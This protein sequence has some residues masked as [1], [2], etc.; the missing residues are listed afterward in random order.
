MSEIRDLTGQRFGRLVVIEPTNMRKDCGVVWRCRCDCGALA[1]VTSPHLTT[2]GTRSCGCLRGELRKRDLTGMR[3]GRLAAIEPTDKRVNGSVVWKCR[4]DCGNFAYIPVASLV[5]ELTKSCGCLHKDVM[6]TRKGPLN[7]N[8]NPNKTDDD[9]HSD[10]SSPKYY[11]WRQMVYERDLFVC[12]KCGKLRGKLNA[13]HIL[14]FTDNPGLRFEL[15]NGVTLCDECHKKFHRI[16]GRH[17]TEEM[18]LEWIGDECLSG[19]T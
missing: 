19:T 8:W 15:N 5:A 10:R 17:S 1:L 4:C 13:H 18:F 11:E 2:G 7:P 14:G 3:F 6:S 9:R 12:Q 16:Y